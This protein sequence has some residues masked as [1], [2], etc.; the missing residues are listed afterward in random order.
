MVSHLEEEEWGSTGWNKER[1]Y[2]R[3]GSEKGGG[4]GVKQ[5][6]MEEEKKGRRKGAWKRWRREGCKEGEEKENQRRKVT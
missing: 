6:V 1:M 4:D 5:G 2:S 3:G